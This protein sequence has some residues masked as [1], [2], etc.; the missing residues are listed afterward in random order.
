MASVEGGQGLPCVGHC[1]Q[2]STQ[3]QQH[4]LLQATAELVGG[5]SVKNYLK[6]K[7][8]RER[9]TQN[10]EIERNREEQRK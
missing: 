6:Q 5:T 8:P 10:K 4:S 2:L 9:G 3:L 1:F 7:T